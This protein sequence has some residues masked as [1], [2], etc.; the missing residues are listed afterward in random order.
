MKIKE[1]ERLVAS[2]KNLGVKDIVIDTGRDGV[3]NYVKLDAELDRITYKHE[4]DVIVL[5]F[6]EDYS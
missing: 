1:L 2:A 6:Y 3:S 5:R 4:D